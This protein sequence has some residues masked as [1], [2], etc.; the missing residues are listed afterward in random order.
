MFKFK[1]LLL[2]TLITPL[3]I[4]S[5]LA[6]KSFQKSVY[7]ETKKATLREID[8]AILFEIAD[9]LNEFEDYKIEIFSSAEIGV[10]KAESKK[11]SERRAKAVMTYFTQKCIDKNKFSLAIESEASATTL[12]VSETE[13]EQSRRVEILVRYSEKT[14]LSVFDD[15][16]KEKIE[17]INKVKLNNY[18]NNNET[19]KT[20]IQKLYEEIADKPTVK[21]VKI[22]KTKTTKVEGE[23]GTVLL[24]PSDALNVP[25]GSQ[26]TFILREAYKMSDMLAENLTTRAG[27]DMLASGGMVKITAMLDGKEIQP[28]KPFILMMPKD[29]NEPM[30]DSMRLFNGVT[31]STGNVDWQLPDDG[32]FQLKRDTNYKN[33][34]KKLYNYANLKYNHKFFTDTCSC[35]KMY[36]WKITKSSWKYQKKLFKEGKITEKPPRFI[37]S[38]EKPTQYN[39]YKINTRSQKSLSDCGDTLSSFCKAIAVSNSPK[40]FSWQVR[41]KYI[42]EW[43]VYKKRKKGVETKKLLTDVISYKKYNAKNYYDYLKIMS[44]HI[45]SL[46]REISILGLEKTT[47]DS[48]TKFNYDVA[49]Q[50]YKK[51]E[52]QKHEKL[53][54]DIVNGKDSSGTNFGI[55]ASYYLFEAT[56]FNWVNCDYFYRNSTN[57]IINVVTE[58]PNRKNVNANLL[59]VKE[60][61]ILPRNYDDRFL[62][63]SNVEKNKNAVLVSVKIEKEKA[64]LAMKSVETSEEKVELKYEEITPQLLKEKLKTLDK[65]QIKLFPNPTSDVLNIQVNTV[66]SKIQV[67]NMNGQ[68]VLEEKN[69]GKS[70]HQ[71]NVSHLPN[72]IYNIRVFEGEILRGVERT[73]VSH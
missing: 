25:E 24:I 29:K 70:E 3:S 16:N 13:K 2:I 40:T 36:V 46:E 71:I 32:G 34:A 28:V 9:T 6:Q 11:L 57:D 8:E 45:D 14:G 63:F 17:S 61:V 47:L 10:P 39:F 60:N 48:L 20:A 1:K 26:V 19:E 68:V 69:L 23:K 52:R 37:Y 72:N 30:R 50:L 18:E 41:H 56:D 65:Y 59:F 44:K 42:K 43:V 21:T 53:M 22:S 12:K 38:N 27:D 67:V 64:Y 33:I 51:R 73:V 31:D 7:F 62:K 5:L 15:S 35:N 54:D 58:S 4:F 55:A 66:F 49:L